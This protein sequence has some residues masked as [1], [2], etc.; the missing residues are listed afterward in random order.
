VT[1]I[2]KSIAVEKV[3]PNHGLVF[4]WAIICQ[5]ID[6]DGVASDYYD[7]QNDHI[8][9]AEML[10]AS[11]SFMK[12][13]RT[14]KEMH[15]GESV[16]CVLFATP[17]TAELAKIWKTDKTGLWIGVHYDDPAIIAKYADGTYSGFSI[18]GMAVVEE[19]AE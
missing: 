14:S 10:A 13:A 19:Q 4:G 15:K 9:E 16:G 8:S 12:S 1:D 5:Q 11:V 3:D 6:A 2:Q 18:G 7:T 17:V